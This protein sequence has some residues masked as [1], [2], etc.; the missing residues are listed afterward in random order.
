M[1]TAIV[2][3][4][5]QMAGAIAWDEKTGIASFEYEPSFKKMGWELSPL[6]MPLTQ[7]QKIYSFP[8]LRRERDSA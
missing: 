6:K 1:N 7:E 8:E 4:W 3:I 5:G 2:K